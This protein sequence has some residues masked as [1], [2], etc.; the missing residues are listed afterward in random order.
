MSKTTDKRAKTLRNNKIK[1]DEYVENNFNVYTTLTKKFPFIDPFDNK[2]ITSL[3][4]FNLRKFEKGLCETSHCIICD[5]VFRND[6]LSPKLHCSDK[7]CIYYFWY[8]NKNIL[9]TQG[10]LTKETVHTWKCLRYIDIA[11][12]KP[13]KYTIIAKL[14]EQHKDHYSLDIIR[15]IYYG[16]K[17][18]YKD[19][20]LIKNKH[21]KFSCYFNKLPNEY[22]M[23]SCAICSKKYLYAD[24][25]IYSNGTITIEIVGAKFSCKSR[26]CYNS[27]KKFYKRSEK[28]KINQS[29]FMKNQIKMGLFTPNVTNSWAK[30][31]CYINNIPFRSTWEAYFYLFENL[32]GHKLKYEYHRIPYTL[33][34]NSHNYIVDFSD[35]NTLYEIKP[36]NAITDIKVKAKEFAAVNWCKLHNY[37]FKY[38]TEAWFYENYDSNLLHNVNDEITKNKMLRNLK[39]FEGNT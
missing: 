1:Y 14:F 8:H 29:L 21:N 7:A 32:N 30:S 2:L 6:T 36:Y 18:I 39:Q 11:V 19:T 17:M 28:S 35:E 24:K 20:M 10:A 25:Y 38:I 16:K 9:S 26:K 37:N 23:R 12:S 22:T 4:Q 33:N 15:D 13:D 3:S 31:R 34:N 27:A 5:N